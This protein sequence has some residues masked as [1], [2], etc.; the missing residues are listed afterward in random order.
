MLHT[1]VVVDH[2]GLLA[3]LLEGESSVDSTPIELDGRSNSVAARSQNNDTVVVE[4]DIVSACVVGSVLGKPVSMILHIILLRRLS[5]QSAIIFVSIKMQKAKRKYAQ[6]IESDLS[7]TF[8]G[9][10]HFYD[11]AVPF[12]RCIDFGALLGESR[13]VDVSGCVRGSFCEFVSNYL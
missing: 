3:L 8:N 1:R 12:D 7:A 9:Q 13:K 4:L 10:M 6:S 11:N 5:W 2:H